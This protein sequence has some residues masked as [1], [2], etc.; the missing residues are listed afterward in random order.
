MHTLLDAGLV[1]PV[2]LDHRITE[3]V[4]LE[5]TP[6]HI[7]GH[8]SVHIGSQGQR[9]LITGDCASHPVQWAEPT[10]AQG[11]NIDVVQSTAT[12]R[13]LLDEHAD[14]GTT[15]LGTH[16]PPPTAGRLTKTQGRSRFVPVGHSTATDPG[17]V[18][19]RRI[20]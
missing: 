14:S 2:P 11:S 3:S 1:D 13:R 17:I 20:D 9:A 6:G 15:I 18:C 12:R 5:S 4:W 16:Y 19:V 8:M 10:W 7:R